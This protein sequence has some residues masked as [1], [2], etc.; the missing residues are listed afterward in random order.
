[1]DPFTAANLGAA[2]VVAPEQTCFL[3]IYEVLATEFLLAAY[4]NGGVPTAAPTAATTAMTLLSTVRHYVLCDKTFRV[5]VLQGLSVVPAGL[6]SPLII[7]NENLKVSCNSCI[8]EGFAPENTTTPFLISAAAEEG[9]APFLPGFLPKGDGAVIEGLTLTE[10]ADTEVEFFDVIRLSSIGGTLPVQLRQVTI[11]NFASAA[12]VVFLDTLTTK[13]AIYDLS[14]LVVEVRCDSENKFSRYLHAPT[15]FEF[16]IS[17]DPP[18]SSGNLHIMVYKLTGYRVG[19][20]R[21]VSRVLF[22]Q[23][24]HPRK[25][26]H[27]LDSRFDVSQ[28]CP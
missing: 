16:Q 3:S 18:T 6:D 10:A 24:Q 4:A 14:E 22:R 11:R 8:L 17:L 12:P 7:L 5:G 1:M 9:V 20:F 15:P 23:Y 19:C 21:C 25:L 27:A 2:P 26:G 28:C 13:P